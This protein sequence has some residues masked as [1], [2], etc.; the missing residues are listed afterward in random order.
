MFLDQNYLKNLIPGSSFSSFWKSDLILA[1]SNFFGYLYATSSNFYKPYNQGVL[2]FF[3][4][5][6][7]YFD[8]WYYTL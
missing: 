6:H 2:A 1:N 3:L 7:N 8:P 5:L 4:G